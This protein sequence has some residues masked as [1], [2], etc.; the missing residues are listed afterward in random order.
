MN[1]Q[2]QHGW[3]ALIK[4]ACNGHDKCVDTLIRAGA[5]VDI[6]TKYGRTALIVAAEWGHDKCVDMLI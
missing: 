4:A 3:T 2:H 1:V 6:Q 5:D